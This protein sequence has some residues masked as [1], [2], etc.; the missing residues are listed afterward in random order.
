MACESLAV[1]CPVQREPEAAVIALDDL[2]THQTG[3]VHHI[4]HGQFAGA[5]DL[6]V[7]QQPSEHLLIVHGLRHMVDGEQP[8]VDSERSEEHTSE[9][10]SPMRISYAVVCLTKLHTTRLTIAHITM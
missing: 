5:E 4:D 2:A 3:G 10:K 7:E 6:G 1:L 8:R 9:L